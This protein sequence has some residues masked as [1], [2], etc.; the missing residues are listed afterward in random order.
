MP[1]WILHLN[2]SGRKSSQRRV[3]LNDGVKKKRRIEKNSTA[4][5]IT[6][7][8]L[9][10]LPKRPKP[11]VRAWSPYPNRLTPRYEFLFPMKWFSQRG[12]IPTASPGQIRGKSQITDLR[13]AR[14]TLCTA[15]RKAEMPSRTFRFCFSPLVSFSPFLSFCCFFLVVRSPPVYALILMTHLWGHRESRAPRSRRGDGSSG[16]DDTDE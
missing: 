6:L 15:S 8:H 14:L 11:P 1:G 3:R 12:N 16:G 13:S 10:S 7:G 9:C 5:F 4:P 2:D